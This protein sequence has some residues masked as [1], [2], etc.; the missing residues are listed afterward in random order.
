MDIGTE[1]GYKL[2]KTISFTASSCGKKFQPLNSPC[3]KKFTT[4]PYGKKFQ[5]PCDKKF[6]SLNSRGKLVSVF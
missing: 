1:S 5:P 3:G 4:S 2:T 6:Q